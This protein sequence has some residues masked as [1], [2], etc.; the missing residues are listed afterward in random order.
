M[1][2][3]GESSQVRGG[4][5]A[6]SPR[7]T[8][9]NLGDGSSS[10]QGQAQTSPIDVSQLAVSGVIRAVADACRRILRAFGLV[11]RFG[12]EESA[13]LLSHL[14][15]EEAEEAAERL[16][17]AVEALAVWKDDQFVTVTA[18]VGVAGAD[19]VT[20]EFP[21]D[22]LAPAD[23]ALRRARE[24][25]GDRVVAATMDGALPRRE[26]KGT[27]PRRGRGTCTCSRRTAAAPPVNGRAHGW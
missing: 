11:G 8:P 21:N 1:N 17:V 19:C 24:D 12:G 2:V 16:R 20:R 9:G 15:L 27:A 14:S 26:R 7:R 22:L 23:S 25:G 13:M 5:A 3:L 18:S 4:S 6:L 10:Q